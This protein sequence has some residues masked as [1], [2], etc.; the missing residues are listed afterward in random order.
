[1]N[2][3]VR[4]LCYT[5]FVGEWVRFVR[6]RKSLSTKIDRV[7]RGAGSAKG[8]IYI[9]V[10]IWLSKKK[11]KLYW[12]GPILCKNK[13]IFNLLSVG[14][15]LQFLLSSYILSKRN[16]CLKRSQ[17]HVKKEKKDY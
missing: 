13:S 7:F 17:I 9:E 16:N 5:A 12:P 15:N 3:L 6:L 14:E 8:S 1:M 2:S 11:K 4:L 10:A